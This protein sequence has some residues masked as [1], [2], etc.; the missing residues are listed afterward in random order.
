EQDK[1]NN[2]N[3]RLNINGD[4]DNKTAG[5]IRFLA[6]ATGKLRILWGSSEESRNAKFHIQR[7]STYMTNSSSYS[8]VEPKQY[9]K[10]ISIN[11]DPEYIYIYNTDNNA[12]VIYS[13]EYICDKYL[14]DTDRQGVEQLIPMY[15]V[16]HFKSIT[17]WGSVP[18]LN[19]SQD[20]DNINL[21]RSVAKVELYL[22]NSKDYF[23]V[24]MRSMNRT[25]R[26]E[27]MDVENPTNLAWQKFTNASYHDATHCEW[28]DICN[29]GKGYDTS[30]T[31]VNEQV[32]AYQ[33]WLSWFYGSWK[34]KRNVADSWNYST[35]ADGFWKYDGVPS[36]SSLSDKEVTQYP[37]IFNPSIN[38]SDFCE[39]IQKPDV[40]GYRRYILYV[41]DKNIDDPNDAG[42]LSSSPK[43]AHIEYR[44][45]KNQDE[46]LDDNKCHRIY[47]TNYSTNDA[48]KQLNRD[49]F[50]D[51]EIT[52]LDD[53]WP[54]MRNHIYRFYVG[55]NNE[56]QEIYVKVD[57]WG[58]PSPPKREEW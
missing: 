9:Y 56:T 11:A 51:Y 48:I 8:S 4:K 22:P 5:Y 49:Q 55:S 7:S 10:D 24:G 33:N 13:I 41:P 31:G 52:G 19:L 29:Y 6:P 1:S 43:V 18:V 23:Y 50:D 25:S 32:Q 27:P 12:V 35:S 3:N 57:E 47:F 54:I 37:H 44:S 42:L 26:N 16:Q 40:N 14:Y 34:F 58:Y 39:F 28:F 38:R 53:L 21:I 15:G 2:N 17:N 45:E 36:L 20:G 30:K 46:Y